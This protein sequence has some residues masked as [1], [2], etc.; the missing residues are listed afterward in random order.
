MPSCISASVTLP[1]EAV[2]NISTVPVLSAFEAD[3]DPCARRQKEALLQTGAMG[4]A[5]LDGWTGHGHVWALDSQPTRA[6][7]QSVFERMFSTPGAVLC[8]K[9]QLWSKLAACVS[10]QL[11]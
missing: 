10:W 9:C 6:S 11:V 4:W 5:W 1:P 7:F 2:C 8:P 3:L